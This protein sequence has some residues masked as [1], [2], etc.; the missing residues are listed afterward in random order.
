MVTEY[1]AYHQPKTVCQTSSRNNSYTWSRTLNI[2]QI[3]DIYINPI[4]TTLCFTHLETVLTS[5]LIG[6]LQEMDRLHR[7][8]CIAIK[9]Q[10][11]NYKSITLLSISTSAWSHSQACLVRWSDAI[12]PY[13]KSSINGQIRH[14]QDKCTNPVLTGWRHKGSIPQVEL[15]ALNMLLDNAE[16][17]IRSKPSSTLQWKLKQYI[18]PQ[19]RPKNNNH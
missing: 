1:F 6:R 7:I 18:Q 3:E 8:G 12:Q 5:C 9:D 19:Q 2:Y 11:Q 16:N 13:H 10:R 4:H 15:I 14:S 17:T